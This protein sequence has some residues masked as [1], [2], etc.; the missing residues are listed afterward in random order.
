MG[1]LPL[2]GLPIYRYKG[3]RTLDFFLDFGETP[4][5]TRDFLL[6]SPTFEIPGFEKSNAITGH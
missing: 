2:Q 3:G 5:S 4:R 6:R 1:K